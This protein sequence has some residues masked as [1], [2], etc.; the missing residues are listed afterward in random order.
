MNFGSKDLDRPN[1]LIHELKFPRSK[2]VLA[3]DSAGGGLTLGAG[4]FLRDQGIPLP[5][6][7]ELAADIL[8][9]GPALNMAGQQY[10][11]QPSHMQL[12]YVSPLYD[13]PSKTSPLP[14]LFI[15]I[16]TVDRFV[17]EVLATFLKRADAVRA[18]MF[19]LM[20]DLVLTMFQS[21]VVDSTSLDLEVEFVKRVTAGIPIK[22]AVFIWSGQKARLSKSSPYKTF[23][24][25]WLPSYLED[26]RLSITIKT[27]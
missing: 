6:D 12:P 21:M 20:F 8:P 22:T 2:I 27:S 11:A 16:G 4:L 25:D 13:T 1:Y 3:G 7:D 14:P 24:A 18:W 23:E 10:A 15:T 17:A 19:C 9:Q 26:Q 5:S